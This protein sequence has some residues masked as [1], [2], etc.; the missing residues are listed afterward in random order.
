MHARSS[1]EIR[2]HRE[3]DEGWRR[4]GV[5]DFDGKPAFSFLVPPYMAKSAEAFCMNDAFKNSGNSFESATHWCI[6]GFMEN[7]IVGEFSKGNTKNLAWILVEG[8]RKKTPFS[9]SGESNA[10]SLAGRYLAD[11]P[12]YFEKDIVA[13][14]KAIY[15]LKL[16]DEK[17][18]D[19]LR[20]NFKII[21]FSFKHLKGSIVFSEARLKDK[22]PVVTD[23][24]Y[25]ASGDAWEKIARSIK[26]YDPID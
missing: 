11:P 25:W 19:P 21:T 6:T 7:P 2:S 15:K 12:G 18:D 17:T 20:K 16:R 10:K 9:S 26:F 23:F 1:G 13:G 5:K 3:S 4:V 14:N 24:S 8:G 22:D